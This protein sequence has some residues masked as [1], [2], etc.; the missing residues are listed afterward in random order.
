MEQPKNGFTLKPVKPSEVPTRG[1]WKA[2]ALDIIE[3]FDMMPERN[4]EV[5]NKGKLLKS[6]KELMALYDALKSIIRKNK[7]NLEV[8]TEG[9]RL[10]LSKDFRYFVK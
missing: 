2:L 7:L 8:R 1:K 4:I 3:K 5:L 9:G 10:F 6:K